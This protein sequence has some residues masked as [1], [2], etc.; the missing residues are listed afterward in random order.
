MKCP[1]CHQ[2]ALRELPPAPFR[3]GAM[4]GLPNV[5]LH[6]VEI[7]E[8]AACGERLTGIPRMAEL[9]RVLALQ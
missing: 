7:H 4:G 2:D 9:H 3:F 1:T 5:V 6:G 8:C